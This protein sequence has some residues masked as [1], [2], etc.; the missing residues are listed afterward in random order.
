VYESGVEAAAKKWRGL[1]G[2]SL[3]ELHTSELN[4][5][6]SYIIT[7]VDAKHHVASLSEQWNVTWVGNNSVCTH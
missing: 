3:S 4:G 5:E 6:F 7:S 2:A 1:I